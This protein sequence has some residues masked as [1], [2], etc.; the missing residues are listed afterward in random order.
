MS[1]CYYFLNLLRDKPIAKLM[2]KGKFDP[3]SSQTA[4]S[5]LMKFEL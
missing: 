3:H 2:G 1:V 5:I 4:W